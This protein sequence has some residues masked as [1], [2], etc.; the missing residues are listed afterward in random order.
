[1]GRPP[2]HVVVNSWNYRCVFQRNMQ[3]KCQLENE[4]HRKKILENYCVVF[5]DNSAFPEK[6]ALDT[7]GRAAVRSAARKGLKSS[8]IL[9]CFYVGAIIL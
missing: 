6:T 4:T 7:L 8:L 1:M 2:F 3:V 5:L 9:W